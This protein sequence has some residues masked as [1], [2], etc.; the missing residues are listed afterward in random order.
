MI[1]KGLIS[2]VICT[3]NP[4]LDYLG[5]VLEGL[6]AQTLARDQWELVIVDNRSDPP[7]VDRLPHASSLHCRIVREETPG[8]V[9]ARVRGMAETTGSWIVYV[10]D[11]NVLDKNYLEEL[12]KLTLT[13][14]N[15]ALWS[16]KI[17]PEFES[18]P[19]AKTRPYWQYLAIRE[20][21]RTQWSNLPI[22]EILPCGAG[23]AVRRDV[24]EN[25]TEGLKTNPARSCLGRKENSLL[26]GEDT[27]IGLTTCEM[28]LGVGLSRTLQLT[29]LISARRVEPAYLR[30]IAYSVT[31]SHTLLD[32]LRRRASK[33]ALI[34]RLFRFT[35]D[36]VERNRNGA[37]VSLW[38]AQVTGLISARKYFYREFNASDSKSESGQT[39]GDAWNRYEKNLHSFANQTGGNSRVYAELSRQTR[40]EAQ[41]ATIKGSEI[42]SVCAG[43]AGP[44]LCSYVLW[45][46]NRSIEMGL[47]RIYFISRDGEIL[48]EIA[49][50]LLSA[51]WPEVSLDL[52]Y[53]LGSRRAWLL[54][55][56]AIS[57]RDINPYLLN[58]FRNS[59][60][61]IIFDRVAL[62]RQ[63]C[64]PV[65][66]KYGF[67]ADDWERTFTVLDLRAVK[68]LV[69]D[70]DLQS[71]I[72][73]RA[74]EYKEST[75][76]YLA[77]EGLF[78]DVPY[79]MADLGWSGASKGAL[80]QILNVRSKS[81]APFFLFGRIESKSGD[82]R[83]VS[84]AYLFNVDQGVGNDRNLTGINVLMEMFCSSTSEGLLHYDLKGGKY[85]P[86]LR[87]SKAD[88]IQDWGF[89]CMRS[90]ILQFVDKLAARAPHLKKPA[91][92][93]AE[94]SDAL[95]KS[96]W[97]T[98]TRHEA[99]VWGQFPFEEDPSAS[100]HGHL[101]PPVRAVNFLWLFIYGRGFRNS[102]EWC[103]G[104]IATHPPIIGFFWKICPIGFHLR[105]AIQRLLFGRKG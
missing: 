41:V 79:A 55:S 80:E 105:K 47:K 7:L 91:F 13:Y 26:A 53:L 31:Y 34:L 4:R 77:Q 54:P 33:R 15:V 74:L 92:L 86:V 43:V 21:D 2:V 38:W 32:L 62:T 18:Q 100:A 84:H 1:T 98:P 75:L 89:D 20:V 95:L 101:V 36:L 90:S 51:F 12:N 40:M 42:T 8:L 73:R 94:A 64:E 85:E 37:G 29:H 78:D 23:M 65:L 17:R 60:L 63:E 16:G 68:A 19:P 82:D 59:S 57:K 93:P 11:D 52:R 104:I 66:L 70:P 25:W 6:E 14:P 50:R 22:P 67:T 56:F 61:K 71:W 24:M 102:S 30:K 35:F 97:I 5:R 99:E 45:I 88:A 103:G 3:Y 28:G 83:S 48:L 49:R 46:L 10:D 96:F 69:R 58:F 72:A 27:D 87:E 76:G 81:L 9:A 39:Q 44:V